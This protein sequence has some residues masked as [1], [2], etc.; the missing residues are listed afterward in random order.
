MK[1]APIIRAFFFTSVF[2]GTEEK[3]QKN[4][5]IFKLHDIE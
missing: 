4:Q 2:I 1:T 3:N 5:Q